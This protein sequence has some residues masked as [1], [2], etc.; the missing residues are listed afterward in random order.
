MCDCITEVDKSM[1]EQKQG[2]RLALAMPYK[3]IRGRMILDCR[4]Q[5]ETER[6]DDGNRKKRVSIMATYCPFCGVKYP[7]FEELADQAETETTK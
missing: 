4:A 1:E 2:F 6:V 3:Q 7:S 5:V